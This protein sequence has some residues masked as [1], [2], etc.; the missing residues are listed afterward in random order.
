MIDAYEDN[1]RFSF[2]YNYLELKRV[3]Y[4]LTYVLSKLDIYS[5]ISKTKFLKLTSTPE[6]NFMFNF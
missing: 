3:A 5:S 1:Q 4:Q 6:V 2:T